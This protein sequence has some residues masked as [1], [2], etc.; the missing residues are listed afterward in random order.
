MSVFLVTVAVIPSSQLCYCYWCSLLMCA[1]GDVYVFPSCVHSYVWWLCWT[2]DLHIIIKST[3]CF[4]LLRSVI[5][6]GKKNDLFRGI[7][8]RQTPWKK[9]GILGEIP[10]KEMSWKNTVDLLINSGTQSERFSLVLKLLLF[11]L[12]ACRVYRH[13]RAL[14]DEVVSRHVKSDCQPRNSATFKKMEFHG[15][16]KTMSHIYYEDFLT[17]CT[18]LLN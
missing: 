15:L 13:R 5:F 6:H 9:L 18:I 12:R 4:L 17:S 14:T 1:V 2:V 11:F 7:P 8:R 3:L 10:P 16:P